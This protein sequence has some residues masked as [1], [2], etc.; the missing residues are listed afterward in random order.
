M[1]KGLDILQSMNR[2]YYIVDC[3]KFIYFPRIVR[4]I[5]VECCGGEE[6]EFI[7][8][9][10]ESYSPGNYR[11]MY[12]A[13]LER[14]KTFHEAKHYAEKLNKIPKNAKRAKNWN[15]VENQYKLLLAC[16]RLDRRRR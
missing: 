15:S 8:D 6:I 9:I 4:V 13:E 10:P 1:S 3:E 5:G 7:I 12:R 11:K 16:Y 14:F 2:E